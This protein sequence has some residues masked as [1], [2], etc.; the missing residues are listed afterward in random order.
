[1]KK[2]GKLTEFARRMRHEPSPAEKQM[3]QLLRHRKL[4]GF[5]FRRQQPISPYVVDYYCAVARLVVELDGDSH[6]G[7]EKNDE[8]RDSFLRSRGYRILRFWN[9][10]LFDDG[11]AV[12]ETIYLAC[13]EGTQ[14][15]PKVAH[16]LNDLGHF[17]PSPPAPLPSGE[18]GDQK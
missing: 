6:S 17:N 11:E 16:K 18:R 12:L 4:A 7:S 9:N 3:W 2:S 8:M 5:R 1:M 13:I 15:N 10:M 14:Q